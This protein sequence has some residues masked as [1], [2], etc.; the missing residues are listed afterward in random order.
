[1]SKKS[2]C[3]ILIFMKKTVTFFLITQALFG[4]CSDVDC[5]F[6]GSSPFSILEALYQSSL[7]K[8]TLV[9]DSASTYG[10][11]WRTLS[12]CGVQGVD[13]GCHEIGSDPDLEMF[14][15]QCMGCRLVSLDDKAEMGF[16]FSGGCSEL[17]DALGQL[18]SKSSV[19]MRLNTRVEEVF[20]QGSEALVKT[21]D[22]TFTAERIFVTPMSGFSIW[23]GDSL[24][25]LSDFVEQTFNHFYL[26]IEDPS[27]PRFSYSTCPIPG[28]T[29]LMNLT[30]FTELCDSGRHLVIVQ[31]ESPEADVPSLFKEIQARGLVGETAVLLDWEFH[32]YSRYNSMEE[33]LEKLGGS[34]SL[35]QMLDTHRFIALAESVERFRK[36][37]SPEEH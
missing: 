1:M 6:I 8:R 25:P 32:P 26:L 36:V 18:L 33:V 35:F 23:E 17:M 10:G 31:T 30:H 27:T 20:S 19:Q 14:L 34:R 12:I 9:V 29:R 7:G 24:F 16:Y 13:L 28:T 2:L 21:S 37:L 4:W 5:L 22:G 15:T 3:G 11:A